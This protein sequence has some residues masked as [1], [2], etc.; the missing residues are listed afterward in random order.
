LHANEVQRIFRSGTRSHGE[1]L[2]AFVAPG[3]GRC[4]VVAS[5]KVGGAVE[6][7]RAKRV[8]REAWR[9]ASVEPVRTK[10]VVLVAREGIRG[11]KSQELVAEIVDLLHAQVSG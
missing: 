11:V 10:D 1:R 9:L 6:R 3:R 5:K 7:N 4:A 8:L 2:V